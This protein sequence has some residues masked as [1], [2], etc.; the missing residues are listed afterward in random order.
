MDAA[1]ITAAIWSLCESGRFP[2]EPG[3]S[4]WTRAN[5]AEMAKRVEERYRP[6]ADIFPATESGHAEHFAATY[7]DQL[8]YDCAAKEW[9]VFDGH[10]WVRDVNLEVDRLI[11]EAGRMRQGAAIGN[12]DRSK[13]MVKTECAMVRSHVEHLARSVKPLTTDGES[14]NPDPWLLGVENGVVDLRTTELREGRPGDMLTLWVPVAYD[15]GAECPYWQQFIEDIFKGRPEMVSYIRRVLGYSLTAEVT[16]QCFWILFGEGANGKS[17]LLEVM[18]KV[19]GHYGWPIPFPGAGWNNS[20]SE[21]QKAQLPG[22]R[23]VISSEGGQRVVLNDTFVKDLSGGDT[24]NARHPC[25]RPFDFRPACKLFL[26]VNKKPGIRDRT[27]GM[28]RKVKLIEFRE[29]FPVAPK[30]AE[31]FDTELP[32][33]LTWLV[34]GCVEWQTSGLQ[35]PADVDAATAAY[36]DETD[37]LAEFLEGFPRSEDSEIRGRDIFTSYERWCDARK[38]IDRL[39]NRSFPEEMKKRFATKKET[40]GQ[41]PRRGLWYQGIGPREYED[42]P[43]F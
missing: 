9:R 32:G 26:R 12:A 4:A 16:E 28:W 34:R 27:H 42:E 10:H 6:E 40:G 43:P 21:Y 2:C 14:W 18:M 22:R 3:K 30:F 5:V 15:P 23:L 1:A 13:V 35:H 29:T 37:E 25:G 19:I 20:M 39:T 41:N 8:R 33:I 11:L 24:L 36:R 38:I 17:T 31:R 7:V